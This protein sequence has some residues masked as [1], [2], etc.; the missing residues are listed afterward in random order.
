MVI[1]NYTERLND[2]MTIYNVTATPSVEEVFGSDPISR[3]IFQGSFMNIQV[4]VKFK[5]FAINASNE[6]LD[7]TFTI[8]TVMVYLRC[9]FFY[10]YLVKL[11]IL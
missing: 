1:Q 11:K 10:K 6:L 3:S 9:D 2:T 5:M 8:M 7:D 4:S